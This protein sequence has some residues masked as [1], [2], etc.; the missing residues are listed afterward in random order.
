MRRW[1]DLALSAQKSGVTGECPKCG[2]VNTDYKY[3]TVES[4]NGY[5]SMW[6][7]DCGAKATIDCLVPTE[8]MSKTA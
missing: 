2:S 6:C 4:P 5:I 3:V 8:A 7:D 1:I